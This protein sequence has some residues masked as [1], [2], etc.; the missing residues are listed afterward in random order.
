MIHALKT[1]PL[2][3]EASAAGVRGFEVRKY[4]RPFRPGDFVAL[5]EWDSGEYTGRC[6]L[7]KIIYILEDPK[8]CKDG[9]VILGLE[10][11]I[12][13]MKGDNPDITVFDPRERRI[14]IYER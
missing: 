8:Y 7:Q 10:P 11:C 3:F 6:I 4:D 9:Y 13:R 14:P 12:I 5:N 2:F 1:E